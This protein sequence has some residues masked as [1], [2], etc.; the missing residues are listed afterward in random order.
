MLYYGLI[1]PFLSCG[2]IVWGQSAKALTRR[3]F[4]LQKRAVRYIA[5]LKHLDSCKDSFGHLKIL[6]VYS[7]YIQETILYV[8]EN[9]NCTVNEHIHTHNTRNNKDSH[10]YGHNLEIYNS[11]PSV[12]GCIYYNKLPNNIKQI[13]NINQFKKKLKE[14]LIKRCY[15]SIDDYLNEDFL[16]TGY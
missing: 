16:E 15:Y 10:I 1:Y 6:T 7:L 13:E 14:L 9:C 11:K 4:I 2:I 3:I 12:A 8:K 5:G